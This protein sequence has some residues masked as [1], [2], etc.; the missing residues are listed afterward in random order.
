MHFPAKF[1]GA[2]G[3][4]PAYVKYTSYCDITPCSSCKEHCLIHCDTNYNDMPL[5]PLLQ[6]HHQEHYEDHLNQVHHPER[7]QH[8][9]PG[10]DEGLT[11]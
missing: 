9:G 1:P 11:R 7:Q 10:L 8:R 4:I 2:N 3:L 6:S 5:L